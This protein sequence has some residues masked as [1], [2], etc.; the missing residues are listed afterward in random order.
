MF[1]SSPSREDTMKPPPDKPSL[2]SNLA[3]QLRPAAVPPPS[4]MPAVVTVQ[5]PPGT[6]VT[7]TVSSADAG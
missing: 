5:L 6:S 7:I 3:E 1:P 2:A 4:P